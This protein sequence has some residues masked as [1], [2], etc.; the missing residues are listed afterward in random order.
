MKNKNEICD[1]CGH[2][3]D[4]HRIYTGGDKRGIGCYHKNTAGSL[5]CPCKKFE[6]QNQRMKT[7]WLP[8]KNQSPEIAELNR[9][10]ATHRDTQSPIGILNRDVKKGE[11]IEAKDYE[12]PDSLRASDA[13]ILKEV[14]DWGKKKYGFGTPHDVLKKAIQLT[15][16]KYEKQIEDL[17]IQVHDLLVSQEQKDAE[18]LRFLKSIEIKKEP[19][20]SEWEQ[21]AIRNKIAELENREAKK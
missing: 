16:E 14:Y 20:Y 11:L 6:P 8:L 18:F 12:A 15:K 17:C 2:K 21:I 13:E 3:K 5:D 19:E 10:S 4:I 1:N 9:K 7:G